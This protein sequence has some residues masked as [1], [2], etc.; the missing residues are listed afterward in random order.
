MRGKNHFTS[1][2][3]INNSD[4]AETKTEYISDCDVHGWVP[5]EQKK[6]SAMLECLVSISLVNRGIKDCCNV[7][8]GFC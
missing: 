6:D 8:A 1:A 7:K 4:A 3:T 2:S 5:G